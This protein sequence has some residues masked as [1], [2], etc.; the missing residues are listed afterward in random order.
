M[1]SDSRPNILLYVSHDTGQHIRPYGL[2]TVRTP[3]ADRMVSE[4]VLFQKS[5]CTA[6]HCSP[7]RASLFTGRYPHA[8]G[9]LGLTGGDFGWDLENAD[10]HAASRFHGAGYETALF[11][12]AHEIKDAARL[13]W[14][15]RSPERRGIEMAG[16]LGMWLDGRRNPDQPFFAVCGTVE[17]H[18]EFGGSGGEPDDSLG[19]TVPGYLHDGPGTR[20]DL[21]A[22]QGDVNLWDKG[23]G[24]LLDL[25]DARGLSS[26]TIL[27]ATSDHGIAFPRAKCTLYD[28]GIEVLLMMRCPGMLSA[29][30]EVGGLVSNVDILPTLL[31]LA[32]IEAGAD[33]HGRSFRSLL[34]GSGSH[35]ERI[36]AEKTYHS[37]YD[38]MRAV[39]DRRFKY[40][41]NFEA[42]VGVEV[43]T[44]IMRSSSYPE[45][46]QARLNP[47]RHPS[48]ELY[49][50]EADPLEQVNLATD[51]EYEETRRELAASL[52]EWME[53][54][55]DP[56]RRGPVPSP[57]LWETIRSLSSEKRV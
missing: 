2:R 37:Y 8:T 41:R 14:D 15:H 33:I 30:R 45:N 48:E 36:F 9:V 31:D 18:R 21:A 13:P 53:E 51:G 19:V 40:I 17:T 10:W 39:R 43:A 49:D 11:G 42:F 26:N 47:L 6:P 52:W 34:D 16:E 22:L 1:P 27:L 44:D 12:I 4:G 32:G 38:P 24:N 3:N 5:F 55:D 29:S 23:L 35:R 50:L 56:L 25:L 20:S 54:T 46:I 57:V 7:S 28:P